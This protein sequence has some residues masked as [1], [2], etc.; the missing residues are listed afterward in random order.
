MAAPSP[1]ERYSLTACDIF[2]TFPSLSEAS[3]AGSLISLHPELL[4]CNPSGGV[5][6]DFDLVADV[7]GKGS[8][9]EKAQAPMVL[10]ESQSTLTDLQNR[11]IEGINSTGFTVAAWFTPTLEL[12][13]NIEPIFTIG[14]KAHTPT[15]T[16]DDYSYS[17][18]AGCAGYDFQ[19]AEFEKS[20]LISYT[21]GGPTR[22]CRFLR[23]FDLT[24]AVPTHVAVAFDLHSTNIYVNGKAMIVGVPNLFDVTLQHWNTTESSLQL[25]TAYSSENMF[26]G[27][28][29]QIDLFDQ[30]VQASQVTAL[31]QEGVIYVQSPEIKVAAKVDE[32]RI[33]QDATEP[34]LLGLGSWNSTSTVF[35]LQVEL[36]SLP[37]HGV[38]TLDSAPVT[39]KSR[40]PIAMNA[41][42]ISLDYTLTS[43][44]YFNVPAVNAYDQDLRLGSESFK[45]RVLAFDAKDELI[46]TSLTV[47][48]P[49]HV[50]HVNHPGV[51]SVPQDSVLDVIYPT[52]A[53]VKGIKFADPLDFNMDRVRV[54]LWVEHGQL[55]L[56]PAYLPLADFDSC[57]QRDGWQCVGDGLEDQRMTFLAIPGDIPFILRSLGYQSLSPGTADEISIRVSDGSGGLCLSENEHAQYQDDF[58]NVFTSIRDECF[59]MQALVR[60]PGFGTVDMANPNK[61]GS[62]GIFGSGF[63]S[64]ADLLFWALLIVIVAGCA[65]GCRRLYRCLAR[66]IIVEVDDDSVC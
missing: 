8:T 64:T 36:L 45:F 7:Q 21:E 2:R 10:L 25:F 3:Y 49:V 17:F 58:G 50:V 1:L 32:I 26:Q 11:L 57:S 18:T 33:R 15:I 27:A 53:T 60:Y 38:L 19:I 56:L 66:G 52:M 51:L 62:G 48:Q 47:I 65:L 43:P 6:I 28:I 42:S 46:A 41:S 63:L 54:D 61:K 9:E 40:F 5:S 29:H 4:K 55:S 34:V 30:Y 31:H 59:Q 24:E 16:P 37:Q 44:D 23:T 12:N 20:I 14:G 39:A 13:G 22:S 35:K